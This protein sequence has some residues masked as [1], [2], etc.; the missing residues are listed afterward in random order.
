MSKSN[1][2]GFKEYSNQIVVFEY[3]V[4]DEEDLP[5]EETILK[6]LDTSNVVENEFTCNED[7]KNIIID[8]E[9]TIGETIFLVLFSNLYTKLKIQESEKGNTVVLD[10][11]EIFVLNKEDEIEKHY[12]GFDFYFSNKEDKVQYFIRDEH[13]KRIFNQDQLYMIQDDIYNGKPTTQYIDPSL[14]WEE[15]RELRIEDR[16]LADLFL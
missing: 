5:Y 16:N 15:M 3:H 7:L 4:F 8:S 10:G 2:G 11:E 13:L 12:M 6:N 14:D 1:L 9:K